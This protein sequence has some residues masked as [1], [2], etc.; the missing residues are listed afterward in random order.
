MQGARQ[1]GTK[2]SNYISPARPRD[3][4]GLRM[5]ALMAL[6]VG[7][8]GFP[9]AQAGYFRL[10]RLV[11]MQQ[12]F[13]RPPRLATLERWRRSAPPGFE[14]TLKVL[15]LITHTSASPT[16]RRL[17]TPVPPELRGASWRAIADVHA[18]HTPFRPLR[19]A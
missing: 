18:R 9:M 12:T 15:Q 16:Y 8:C 2:V 6:H 17:G 3:A 10:F 19:L 1:G 11:E 13:Y 14:F 7:C 4:R 5:E